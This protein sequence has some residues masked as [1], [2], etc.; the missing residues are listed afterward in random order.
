MALIIKGKFVLL[1]SVTSF[2]SWLRNKTIKRKITHIQL[3]CTD[4]PNYKHFKGD[5]HFELVEGMESSHIARGFNG[6]G[7]NITIFPDGKIMLCRE[8]DKICAC[9]SGH[10]TG[11][12]CIENLGLFDKGKDEM[13]EAQRKAIIGTVKALLKKFNLTPE[14]GVE[15]HHWHNSG[16]SCPGNNFFGGNTKE[17]YQKN[18]LPLLKS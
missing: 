3:H 18:L 2:S 5:N 8:F 15:Y 9:I 6:I 11:G 16:K 17:A 14:T 7:Q 1:S 13:S 4:T 10:N 12:L